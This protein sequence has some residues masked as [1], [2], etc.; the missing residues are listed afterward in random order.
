MVGKRKKCLTEG[1]H[2]TNITWRGEEDSGRKGLSWERD[3]NVGWE[4]G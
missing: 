2:R 1:D 3:R 4:R